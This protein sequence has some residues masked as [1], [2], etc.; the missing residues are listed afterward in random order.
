MATPVMLPIP[1]A[2]GHY[3]AVRGQHGLA[4]FLN[5]RGEL[6]AFDT[7]GGKRWQVQTSASWLNHF[8]ER[9][10]QRVQPTLLPLAFYSHAIPTATLV[11]GVLLTDSG[12]F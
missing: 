1:T 2:S 9:Q 7:H 6:T 5:S 11:A 4:V 8:G 10:Y 3:R 12:L